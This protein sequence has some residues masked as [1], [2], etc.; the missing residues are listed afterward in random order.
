MKTPRFWLRSAACLA[1]FLG[2]CGIAPAGD[3]ILEGGRAAAPLEGIEV[4]ILGGR[5]VEAHAALRKAQQAFRSRRDLQGVGICSIL[6]GISELRAANLSASA[7]DLAQGGESFAALGDRVG[8]WLAEWLLGSVKA[9]AGRFD[10]ALAH[11]ERSLDAVREAR[12]SQAAVDL[13]AWR[14]VHGSLGLPKEI[15]SRRDLL[16]LLEAMSRDAEVWVLGMAGRLTDGEREL[17]RLADFSR[18]LDGR[19]DS[20][21]EVHRGELR[22]GQGRL[23]EARESFRRALEG[24]ASLPPA[25]FRDDWPELQILEHLTEIELSAGRCAEALAWSDRAL[26]ALRLRGADQAL[27]SVRVRADRADILATCGDLAR[28]ESVLSEAADAAKRGRSAYLQATTETQLG[29]LLAVSAR[30]FEPAARHLETAVGLF[31]SVDAPLDEAKAWMLLSECYANLEAYGGAEAALDMARRLARTKGAPW[32]EALIEQMAASQG[33]RRALAQGGSTGENLQRLFEVLKDFRD[34]KAEEGSDSPFL[35]PFLEGYLRFRR[36]EH[37]EA[38]DLW[39]AALGESPTRELEAHLQAAIGVSYWAEG[40]VEQALPC[41]R[42]AADRFEA[43][44]DEVHVGE[45]LTSL[46]GGPRQGF[47]Q[48]LVEMLVRQNRPREAFDI[49]EQARARALLLGLGN[50]RLRPN[51]GAD[52]H[53]VDES[54]KLRTEILDLELQAR[55]APPPETVRFVADLQKA[56]KRYEWLLVRLKVKSGEYASL[57]RVE[58]L[59]IKA[60]QEAL[61]QASTLISFFVTPDRVHA[62]VIDRQTFHHV[63]LPFGSEDR[64]RAACWA[65]AVGHI[66]RGA[67]PTEPPCGDQRESPEDLYDKLFAPLA[68]SVHHPKLILIPHGELHYLPFAALRNPRTGRFLVEDYTLTYA[69]SASTLR[70]LRAKESPVEGRALVLGAPERPEKDLLPLRGM[71]TEAVAVARMLHSEPRLGARA[72]ESEIYRRAGKL[73]LLHIAAHAIYDP[74]NPQFSRIALGAAKAR[75]GNLEVHEI[76]AGLDLTG[77]NLVVLSACETARG[78]RSGGDE[79]TSLTRAFLYAGSPGVVS[80][81]WKVDD[82]ASSILIEAFYRRLLEGA[83]AAEALREAQ[84]G[85]LRNPRTRDPYKWAAFGLAGDPQGRWRRPDP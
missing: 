35:G 34:G 3:P 36:G 5:Q 84:V 11:Y 52:Q 48:A 29:R 15:L 20:V 66:F 62:W 72:S 23:E 8:I 16:S 46:L 7:A 59:D 55:S 33:T 70:F 43:A 56:R 68:A 57:T 40:K 82:E 74:V 27:R 45:L 53:L 39:A 44:I 61:P 28:A 10:T 18:R 17:S 42:R 38:R 51:H 64:R 78:E 26:E 6:L 81:L 69:P 25:P 76:L 54:E 9:G 63:A 24:A 85:M 50:H 60:V 49:A 80:T 14:Y 31:Q 37:A 79:I 21:V 2:A 22:R 12:D 32:E 19:F 47:F 41:F 30:R 75:D 1:L 77:V 58:P 67:K 71:T 4:L 83:P 73:D 65:D 13:R